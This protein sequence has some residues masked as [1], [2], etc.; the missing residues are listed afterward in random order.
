MYGYYAQGVS[1]KT[2]ILPQGWEDRLVRVQTPNTDLKVGLCLEPCDLAASKLAAGRPKD[3]SFVDA[4]LR[5]QMVDA[6]RLLERI[7]ILPVNAETKRRL[8]A[9]VHAHTKEQLPGER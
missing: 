7:A 9:W 8:C 2:A 6:Q 4:L 1:P 3:H 5:H